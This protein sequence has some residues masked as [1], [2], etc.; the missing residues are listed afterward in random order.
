VAKHSGGLELTWANKDKALLL[1]GDGKY[2]Y[3][4]VDR[5]DYP[6]NM[7]LGRPAFLTRQSHLHWG[8]TA[9]TGT[10]NVAL[11]ELDVVRVARWCAA[12]VPEHARHHVRIECEVV[13]GHGTIAKRRAPWRKDHGPE[14]AVLWRQLVGALVH[15]RSVRRGGSAR[16]RLHGRHQ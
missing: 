5:A 10:S 15:W 4:F 8:P 16:R 6:G 11:P 1:T 9:E 2:D 3:T 13:A 12:R 14:C 7:P